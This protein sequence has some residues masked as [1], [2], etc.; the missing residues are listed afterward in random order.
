MYDVIVIG[1]GAAGMMCAITSAR[2]SKKVLLIEKLPK[3]GSKLKATGGGKCNLSNTLGSE[4]FMA[5]FGKNGR[6]MRDALLS[7]DNKASY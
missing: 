7:F 5:S 3:I 1:A 6:F 4:E 2:D